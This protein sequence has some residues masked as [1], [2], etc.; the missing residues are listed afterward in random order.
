MRF[1]I[2]AFF[3]FHVHF[4]HSQSNEGTRF[5]LA[6]MEHINVGQNTMVVMITSKYAAAGLVEMPLIGWNQS[7]SVG[8]NQVTIVTLPKSAETVGSEN[9]NKNGILI[10][11]DKPVS[12]YMHQ[13]A[14]YRSEA[15]VVLPV[16]ALGNDYYAISYESYQNNNT[17]YPSEF[18]IVGAEPNTEIEILFST[19]T[20]GGRSK[21]NQTNIIL[22]P[23]ETYQVQ[24]SLANGDLTGSRIKGNKP[25]ALFAGNTYTPMPAGCL[26]RDNL[27]EQMYPVSTWGKQF[28]TVLS[29]Q[30]SYDIFRIFASE[31]NTLVEVQGTTLEKYNLSAGTFVEYKKYESTFINA[32]KP[33]AVAQYNVGNACG[34][35]TV[36]DPSMVLLNSIEQIR[37]TVTL[38][39]SSLQQI[40]ENYLNVVALASDIAKVTLDG[41]PLGTLNGVIGSIKGHSKYAFARIKVNAG[42]HTLIASGCGIS[43]TAYG[44]GNAESYAYNGGASF[45]PINAS[46]IP[47]GGCINDSILFDIGLRPPRFN[48]FWDFGKTDTFISYN[49]KKAFSQVGVYPVKLTRLDNCL[50]L[51]DTVRGNL[52]ITMRRKLEVPDLFQVCDGEDIQLSLKDDL[53]EEYEWLGVNGSVFKEKN[54]FITKAKTAMSTDYEVIGYLDGCPTFTSRTKL[55]VMPNPK[56]NLGKDAFICPEE[57][58]FNMRLQAGSFNAYQWQN[59][60]TLPYFDVTDADSFAV[61]VW[62]DFGCTGFD[63]L[64]LTQKCPTKFY[65]PDAF[66]PNGDQ[67]N[68]VFFIYGEDIISL[69]LE[70]YDR[71]GNFIF[72]SNAIDQGW[73]GSYKNKDLDTGAYLWK[74][75]IEGF[76]KNGKSFKEF[77][78]GMVY[79]LR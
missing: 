10:S 20:K 57:A 26:N 48:L 7:F 78:T 4:L 68:D 32:S 73:N 77:H 27:L 3:V 18:I 47:E 9:T 67:V 65:A 69:K 51:V 61:Q 54:P 36:G 6:F 39:N 52:N 16:D 41:T 23:G 64:I 60:S 79:L 42:S 13:Y 30:V 46:P 74:A 15:S 21:G 28:V 29:A 40:T 50:K 76:R 22:G 72:Q 19:S 43:V 71:W 12:V 14:T 62:D 58:N 8:P 38:Y 35:H 24:A 55:Q 63:T 17:I 59:K 11:S 5:R 70:I 33:I 1:L 66:S 56:P 53:S 45:K 31:D 37:D 49:F 25:F 75:E 2:A 34:G 44:Y